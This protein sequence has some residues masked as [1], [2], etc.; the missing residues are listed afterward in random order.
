MQINIS[1]SGVAL[2]NFELACDIYKRRQL[3]LFGVTL[4]ESK[5]TT[6]GREI[7][8]AGLNRF[9]LDSSEKVVKPPVSPKKVV[10]RTTKDPKKRS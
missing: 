5:K 3:T 4:D 10:R 7:F 9:L 1:L 6:I 2:K 8:F